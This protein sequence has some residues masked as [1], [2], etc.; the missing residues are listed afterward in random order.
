MLEP[1]LA[2]SLGSVCFLLGVL[3]PGTC[4]WYAFSVHLLTHFINSVDAASLSRAELSLP[5][6]LREGQPMR[7]GQPIYLSI[8]QSVGV[9]KH[10]GC[11]PEDW[12]ISQRSVG[13]VALKDCGLFVL[14]IDF[15]IPPLPSTPLFTKAPT[16]YA[17]WEQGVSHSA[18]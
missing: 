11:R 3:P 2:L 6:R 13:N 7:E 15:S 1:T 5:D 9:S 8:C 14:L 12:L 17:G 18:F 10:M 4:V 16:Y